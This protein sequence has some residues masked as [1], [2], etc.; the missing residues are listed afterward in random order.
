MKGYQLEVLKQ[1]DLFTGKPSNYKIK[2]VLAVNRLVTIKGNLQS[3][4]EN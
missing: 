3:F 1:K 4:L 2:P